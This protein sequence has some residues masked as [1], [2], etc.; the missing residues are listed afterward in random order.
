MFLT[1]RSPSMMK[2]GL[3][4]EVLQHSGFLTVTFIFNFVYRSTHSM[5]LD[6]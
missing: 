1:G 6:L 5:I 4:V 2:T 3:D